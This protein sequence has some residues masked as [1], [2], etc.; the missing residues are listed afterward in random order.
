M[1]AAADKFPDQK[2][3]TT[4]ISRVLDAPRELVF[5]AMTE[6]E[7][8]V[9]WHHAGDGWTTPF[10]EADLRPG[11][12]LRIGYA[13]PDGKESFVLEGA[14]REVVAPQRLVYE[15]TDGRS[16]ITTL[17][18]SGGKTKVTIELTLETENPEEM[19]RQGWSEHLAKPR[20]PSREGVANRSLDPDRT[21]HRSYEH[22]Y[23][24][25]RSRSSPRITFPVVVSGSA[26]M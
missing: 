11:G 7:H 23:Q 3:R 10:A 2:G 6:P 21:Q 22:S 4:R 12:A 18:D 25:R 24:S 13:S 19:Q 26:S 8:L 17:E 5:E 15:M 1:S 20:E 16:V 14:Y 9:H